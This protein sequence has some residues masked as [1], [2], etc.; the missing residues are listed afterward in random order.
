[1]TSST[2]DE[3]LKLTRGA[4]TAY[5]HA[6]GLGS[7][8]ALTSSTG[9]VIERYTYD[10][11]GT[12]RITDAAGTVLTQSAV[13]NRALFTGREYDQ[14]TGLYSYRA[15]YY[16]SRIGRFLSRDP[17][18]Y[19]ADLNLYRYVDHNPLTWV[20]PTGLEKYGQ[21]SS[22]FIA[23]LLSNPLRFAQRATSST[24]G[25]LDSQG[26]TVGYI[27]GGRRL[28]IPGPRFPVLRPAVQG[29]GIGLFGY[30]LIQMAQNNPQLTP[31][32]L[33]VVIAV[34]TSETI[35]TTWALTKGAGLGAAISGPFAPI[36]AAVGG[37]VGGVF[38]SRWARKA[39]NDYL[40]I[41]GIHLNERTN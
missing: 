39:G 8:V 12:P 24:L 14:E 30:D 6:D 17:V 15:R 13:G 22:A 18:G 38:A 23:W 7:V 27:A 40:N 21:Q 34:R 19:T 29:L 36:G 41:A 31:Q 28:Y 26:I 9:A 3:P 20:D 32:Q 10:V 5:Y 11:Y 16:D 37:A 25:H 4:T 33:Q 35:F 2:L 1:M